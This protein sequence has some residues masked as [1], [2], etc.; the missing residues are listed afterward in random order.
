M[1]SVLSTKRLRAAS[2]TGDVKSSQK[3]AFS[4][5]SSAEGEAL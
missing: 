2:T 1:A 3:R 4:S 5:L